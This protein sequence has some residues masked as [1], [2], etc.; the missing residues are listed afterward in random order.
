M[1]ALSTTRF[2]DYGMLLCEKSVKKVGKVTR[3]MISRKI[4]QV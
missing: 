2:G 3:Q 1:V 4:D